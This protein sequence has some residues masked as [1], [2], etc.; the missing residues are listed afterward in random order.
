MKLWERR[1]ANKGYLTWSEYMEAVKEDRAEI[2]FYL[3]QI[4]KPSKKRRNYEALLP[5]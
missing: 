3:Q 4:G 2:S 1:Q 5:R